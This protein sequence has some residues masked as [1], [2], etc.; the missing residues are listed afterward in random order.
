MQF[1]KRRECFS[2]TYTK[3]QTLREVSADE[4]ELLSLRSKLCPTTIKDICSHHEHL[5]LVKFSGLQ[6]KCCDAFERHKISKPRTK[7][8]RT[9]TL[10][11]RIDALKVGISLVPEE[12]LCSWCRTYIH[13]VVSICGHSSPDSDNVHVD[14]SQSESPTLCMA[15]TV[16]P[17]S[18]STSSSESRSDVTCDQDVN[19]IL[20]S[21]Q[22]TPVKLHKSN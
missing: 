9:I 4:I 10:A 8:L 17:D 21:L 14:L 7:S 18:I 16:L 15:S 12:K 22:Q 13:N 3:F 1:F 5:V 11:L 2:T 20:Q 19:A 6:R